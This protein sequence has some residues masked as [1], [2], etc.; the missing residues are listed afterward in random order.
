ML[1]ISLG[2]AIVIVHCPMSGFLY[3]VCLARFSLY[4]DSLCTDIDLN[5]PF[6]IA[7]A[8]SIEIV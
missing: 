8:T 2:C 5:I 4:I 1:R 6:K 7:I 3:V